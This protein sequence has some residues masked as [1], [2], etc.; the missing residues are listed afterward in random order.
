MQA[1]GQFKQDLRDVK[2]DP[3]NEYAIVVGETENEFT[4]NFKVE[5]IKMITSSNDVV[6]SEQLSAQ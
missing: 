3:S 1:Y 6:M 5:N 4:F 2:H